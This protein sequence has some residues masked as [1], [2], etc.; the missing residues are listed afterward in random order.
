VIDRAGNEVVPL[1]KAA[2]GEVVEGLEVLNAKIW[3]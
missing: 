1:Q 2:G 3:R